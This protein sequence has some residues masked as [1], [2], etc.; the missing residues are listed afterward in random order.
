MKLLVVSD[1][2]GN[3]T[4][5]R[6]AIEKER[7]DAVAHLGDG[8]AD[9]LHVMADWPQ[10]PLYSVS[11]NCDRRSNRTPAVAQITLEG[12]HIMLAHGHTFGVK[13]GYRTYLDYGARQGMD[14]LLS[15]HT[16]IPCMRED[17]P[18]LL[19]NPGSVGNGPAPT[20][21]VVELADGAV[22]N[23]KIKEIEDPVYEWRHL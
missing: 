21:A 2:H 19:L 8:R 11:G 16:H 3:C 1:S 13:S 10:L 5:L 15:G 6:R 17:G 4:H 9:I 18:L 7:P 22:Q 20:Y 12:V 23:W 14:L